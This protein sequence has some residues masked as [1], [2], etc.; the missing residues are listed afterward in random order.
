MATATSIVAR[1]AAHAAAKIDRTAVVDDKSRL[2]YAELERQSNALAAHLQAA[3]AGLQKT[4]GLFLDRS[5]DFVVGALA[6]LKSGAAYVPLDPGTPLD[7]AM[8]ILSDADV[9]LV[10]THRGKTSG[11]PAS[12]RVLDVASV[13]GSSAAFTPVDPDPESL[14]YIVYTSG[15]TG[16]PKGVEITHANLLNLIDWHQAAFNVRPSDRASQV[17]GLAFD[18]TAW[19]VWPHLTA[20]ASLHIAEELTRRSPYSLRDWLVAENITISFVPT[21]LAEPLLQATW[22]A[23]TALRTMLT[24]ADVLHRRPAAGLPFVLVNNY[25]PSECTVVATSG[26]IEADGAA[27]DP[28]PIGAPIRNTTALVLDADLRPVPDGEPGELCL[29]GA[30]V[31]RGYRNLPELTAGRFVTYLPPSGPPMRIYRTGDRVR[32]LANGQLAF[33]G[34][35][36]SQI[37]IRG[38]RVEPGEIVARL[39]RYPGVEASALAVTESAAGPALTAYIVP[40]WDAQLNASD[41]REFLA[42][43]LP[44]YMIPSSFVK[45]ESLP[46][47]ANG[48]LDKSALPAPTAGNLIPGRNAV[49]ESGDGPESMQARIAALVASLLNIPSV[50][51]DDNFF[52]I[53]GHSMLGVQLVARIREMF[54]IK[55]ALRQLFE[56]PTVAALSKEVERL[57]SVEHV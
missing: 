43:R 22:P 2:S 30:L 53:G 13:N 37:K 57:T 44:D 23:D 12:V 48:K 38:Y 26:I 28:P 8:A 52:T 1:I 45:V 16:Q 19:E 49:E 40:A 20:G 5:V 18:A 10:L 3:G 4:V 54:G 32:R 35:L 56:A 34:R 42:E 21:V 31:G 29:G 46:M 15:S 50:G 33:L 47:T 55:L 7:R 51:A 14:A 41:L 9:A 6:V 25:G 11:W 27:G 39:D 17:A 36:D 24:G